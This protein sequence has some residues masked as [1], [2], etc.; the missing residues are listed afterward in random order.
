MSLNKLTSPW[1]GW[2]SL[3]PE[4]AIWLGVGGPLVGVV[5]ITGA[6]LA[7]D[8]ADAAADASVRGGA[9]F[10]PTFTPGVGDLTFAYQKV[11]PIPEFV[12]AKQRY[13]L[14]DWN[15]VDS[16]EN[17]TLGV[18]NTM[19]DGG[20]RVAMEFEHVLVGLTNNTPATDLAGFALSVK[21]RGFGA[22][23]QSDGTQSQDINISSE[24][25]NVAPLP[26][27]VAAGHFGGA[28][29]TAFPDMALPSDTNSDLTNPNQRPTFGD[30]GICRIRTVVEVPFTVFEGDVAE[31]LAL[32]E[33]AAGGAG[34]VQLHSARYRFII[35]SYP[36][37]PPN[38]SIQLMGQL[39]E[40]VQILNEQSRFD[41]APFEP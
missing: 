13:R 40:G 14:A 23:V 28:G 38:R 12:I 19:G 18:D 34:A 15:G 4:S 29:L 9:G 20:R 8:Q 11:I 22:P 39:D 41:E 3:D 27:P 7:A 32:I 36:C 17:G 30:D 6:S 31:V 26:C 25:L 1:A 2:R 33:L 16:D 24:P 5:G 37:Y 10:K 35:P 21:Y